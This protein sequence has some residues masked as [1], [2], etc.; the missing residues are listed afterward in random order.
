MNELT[1]IKSAI[2]DKAVRSYREFPEMWEYQFAITSEK[3]AKEFVKNLD[4]DQRQLLEE[5]S[6]KE[7]DLVEWVKEAIK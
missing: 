2:Q 3:V 7:S 1:E 6:V 5:K 4:N